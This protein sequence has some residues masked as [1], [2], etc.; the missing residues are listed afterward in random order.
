MFAPLFRLRRRGDAAAAQCRTRDDLDLPAYIVAAGRL[1]L[2]PFA[3]LL[4]LWRRGDRGRAPDP[5][6]GRALV[7]A[8]AVRAMARRQRALK[9]PPEPIAPHSSE[10]G[11]AVVTGKPRRYSRIDLRPRYEGQKQ[12]AGK[13]ATGVTTPDRSI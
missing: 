1:Q 13:S 6:A 7:S 9:N 4:G 11:I 8:V 3:D 10:T 12:C 2:P 5:S